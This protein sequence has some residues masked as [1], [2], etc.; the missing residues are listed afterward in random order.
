[1]RILF[2]V[3]YTPN[4]I[5]VRPY[6]LIRYLSARGHEV[7]VLTQFSGESEQADAVA[8]QAHC[9]RVIA[10][11]LRRWR[12]LWN[13]LATLPTGVPLQAAYCWQPAL[14]RQLG[15]LVEQRNGRPSFD[16]IHVEHLRG[17]RYGLY[18]KRRFG[19]ANKQPPI[20]WDSVDC[21]SLLF[22]RAATHSESRLS[23]WV[24]RF[25]LGRTQRYEGW[26]AQQFDRV[27]LTSPIDRDA[28]D[29]LNPCASSALSVLGNGV[30]VEYFRPAE[31]NAREPA[32][33]VVTGKM[34]YH[35]N[36]TMTLFLIREIM[37]A[38]WAQRPDVKV[39]IV[40]K[41]PPQ[42]VRA[43]AQHPAISVTGTVADL[44]P[45]IQHATIAAVPIAYGAGIQNKVLEAMACATPVIATPQAVTALT[46]VPDRELLVAPDAPGLA[47][48][49][50]A[51]L[52]D[53]ARQR[54]IGEAGRAYVETHHNWRN[55]AAQL[56]EIY[57]GIIHPTH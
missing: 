35:A 5:R 12:S 22:R 51:L 3:P 53:P 1:M 26:L 41:D 14:A 28:F 39:A 38:V 45:Y 10:L 57:H 42:E 27:L 29:A 11:P 15:A 50:L 52:A 47:Q 48:T 23:R 33:I 8:L 24:A 2:V 49:I 37:P 18:L 25:E 56:E 34:S 31:G 46:A 40:G 20:V 17:V 7:I 21:I 6:N 54:A 13:C 43:L 4:L 36:V 44:R 32:T 30:D 9:G 16:V 55:I 19:P